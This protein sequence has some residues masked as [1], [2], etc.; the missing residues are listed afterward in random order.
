MSKSK[1]NATAAPP[2]HLDEQARAKWGE[3]WPIVAQRESID[4]GT[5]DALAAYC[6]AYSRWQAAETKVG[7][8]GSVVK[9]PAGFAVVNPYTIIAE[10]AA[11]Q[12]RQFAAELRR[13]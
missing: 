2:A 13:R 10:K 7:E 11:R 8:L 5:L 12:M 1:K 4:Q 6:V 9:S 3:I